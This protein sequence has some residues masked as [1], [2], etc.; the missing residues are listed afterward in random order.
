MTHRFLPDLPID[1]VRSPAAN[2]REQFDEASLATL[3]ET[4]KSVGI[5]QPLTVREVAPD[6]WELLIGE[7]R[8]RAAK[9]AGLT[10]IPA[11]V[12]RETLSNAEVLELQLLE[13]CAREDLNPVEKAKAFDRWM[14]ETNRPAAQL[15]E[16]VGMSAGNVTKL[17][18]LLLLTADVLALVAE[19]RLPMSSAY[20]VARVA[21]HAEQ[22]R[23][24]QEVVAGRL[25]RDKLAAQLKADKAAT[26]APRRRRQ[27]QRTERVV[28]RLEGGRRIAVSGP[29]LSVGSLVQWVGEL[30]S[31]LNGLNGELTLAQVVSSLSGK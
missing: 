10:T 18:T 28:L 26:G 2:V 13:N 21:D 7:R 20:E 9:L 14:R 11:V 23:L 25:T 3:A 8:F 5:K 22:R 4:I 6:S 17:T 30:F 31:R 12:V 15:A 16:R 24:A 27:R 29:G 1:R 19:G